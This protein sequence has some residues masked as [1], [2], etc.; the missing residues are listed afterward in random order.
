MW[1]LK[2]IKYRLLFAFI[3]GAIAES[4]YDCIG[5]VNN[6][7]AFTWED[8]LQ[9]VFFIMSIIVI[10]ISATIEQIKNK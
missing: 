10:T 5:T 7:S 4:I 1:K 2:F 9:A 6:C 8:A 3:V